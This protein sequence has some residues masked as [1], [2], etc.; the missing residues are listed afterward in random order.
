MDMEQDVKL[1]S[2]GQI[3]H[4]ASE[5]KLSGNMDA[6]AWTA[7]FCA[8]NCAADYGTMLGWFSDALM[9]GYDAA[10]HKFDVPAVQGQAEAWCAVWRVLQE[11]EPNIATKYRTLNGKDK[12]VAAIRALASTSNSS[13]EGA[14]C[15][16]RELLEVATANHRITIAKLE[17]AEKDIAN[18]SSE[19][20]SSRAE[21]QRL[22][23]LLN[24]S[25]KANLMLRVNI[26]RMLD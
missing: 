9:T 15:R 14:N 4:G 23:G 19:L 2:G 24:E 26:R 5:S 16:L 13:T 6:A 17:Q 11:I 1:G 21:C 7:E 8:L 3:P 22:Q 25:Q 10:L 20:S 18:R 12:A